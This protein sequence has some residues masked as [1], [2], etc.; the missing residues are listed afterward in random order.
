MNRD[1]A[2]ELP[3]ELVRSRRWL[4]GDALQKL[5]ETEGLGELQPS[6][7]AFLLKA[8]GVEPI[9]STNHAPRRRLETFAASGLR[10]A[11]GVRC[12]HQDQRRSTPPRQRP[13]RLNKTSPFVYRLSATEC[14][15][16]PAKA[17]GKVAREG[18][19]C[20]GPSV[21]PARREATAGR[22]W[23]NRRRSRGLPWGRVR[24]VAEGLER[25]Q[26][27]RV[28]P[29]GDDLPVVAVP[30]AAIV[31]PHPV[32][33]QPKDGYAAPVAFLGRNSSSITFENCGC[34][35]LSAPL[36]APPPRTPERGQPSMKWTRMFGI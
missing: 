29:V 31:S 11:V 35:F 4:H 12:R 3:D 2:L 5:V 6:S 17:R 28:R 9:S 7:F 26:R 34:S 8:S 20:G 33:A 19:A 23:S 25:L 18:P 10:S 15:A 27:Q 13:S 24:R 22:S 36:S 32:P 16:S 30:V 1:D 14:A 21:V